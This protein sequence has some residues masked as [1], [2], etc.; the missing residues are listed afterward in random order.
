MEII[1]KKNGQ[2]IS[3]ENGEIDHDQLTVKLVSEDDFGTY[4]C[5]AI[6][7]EN[8]IESDVSE[9]VLKYESCKSILNHKFLVNFQ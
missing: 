7:F 1:W 2:A 6:D 9:L 3:D 4:S 5:Q 8:G